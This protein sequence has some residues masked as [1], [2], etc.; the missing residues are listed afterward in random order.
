M[1]LLK[2]A[3]SNEIYQYHVYSV[4]TLLKSVVNMKMEHYLAEILSY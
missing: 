3:K 2:R 1:L 4:L